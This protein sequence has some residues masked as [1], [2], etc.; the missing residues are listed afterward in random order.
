MNSKSI[1]NLISYLRFPFYLWGFY[2]LV[3]SISALKNGLN[4]WEE[5]NNL[6][7]LTGMGLA[8]A[9]LK[10]ASRKANVVSNRVWGNYTIR[11]LVIAIISFSI[12]GLIFLGLSTLFFSQTYRSEAV[13]VGMIVLGIGL[14][15]YLKYVVERIE[16]HK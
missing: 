10:D 9:L 3:Q 6:L 4:G 15:G 12:S 13:A 14:L 5:I 2:F 7:I 1:F 11:V 16:S 8:F